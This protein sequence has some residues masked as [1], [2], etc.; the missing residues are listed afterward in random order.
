MPELFAVMLVL[1][2]GY[3]SG[4]IPTSIIVCKQLK[5]ID[6]REHG[7]KN[8]GATNVYRVVGKGPALFVLIVDIIKALTAVAFFPIFL[9]NLFI[10]YGYSAF[11]V[12]FL[13]LLKILG[14]AASVLGHM[15]TIFAQFRGGKGV[16]CM[17]GTFLGIFPWVVLAAA[18]IFSVVYYFSRYVS[19]SSLI[20]VSSTP[21]LLLFFDN[22]LK[23]NV[24]PPLYVVSLILVCAV[25]YR[26]RTNIT[27]LLSGSE[28]KAEKSS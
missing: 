4:S 15:W 1:F 26:H 2:F 20:A 19:L 24:T 6:I 8:P 3:I 14:G 23:H 10:Q 17:I 28:L 9:N 12:N 5:G 13:D 27:R 22:Y 7:S 11:S 18:T 25:L 21:L 16:A